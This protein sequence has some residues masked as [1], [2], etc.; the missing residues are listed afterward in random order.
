[1]KKIILVLGVILVCFL[2]GCSGKKAAVPT[3][4]TFI[5][6]WGATE[7]DHKA[8][9][10]IYMD[11]EKENPDIKINMLSMPTN[12]EMINFVEDM[13]SV[14]TVPD[15][16]FTAGEG[17]NSIYR[18]MLENDMLVDLAPYMEKDF[19]F[20]TSISPITKVTWKQQDHLYTASDVLIVSGGY[21]YNKDLLEL[22][23]IEKIPTTWD[24]FFKMLETINR[25]SQARFSTVEAIR[26]STNTYLYIA[27]NI[28]N[29]SGEMLTKGKIKMSEESFAKVC[30]TWK[31]LDDNIHMQSR[32][33][34]YRDE[35]DLFN[36]G[37]LAIYPNGVWAAS[38]IKPDIN[39]GYALF[40]SAYGQTMSC[41]SAA[42]GYLVGNTGNEEKIQ[43][44][45]RFLTYMLSLPVQK[46]IL[47]ETQQ[48]PQNPDIEI[49]D[50]EKELERFSMA[51]KEI[52]SAKIRLDIPQN[53]WSESQ[54]ETIELY[55]SSYLNGGL[56]EKSFYQMCVE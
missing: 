13:L 45:I 29:D 12:K 38:M 37:K 51:V 42:L 26:P 28:L 48:M 7:E 8:M 15:I 21:W 55:L 50:Y 43:A 54:R 19:E 27:D 30:D 39:A 4:I 46:R 31:R 35:T 14:G 3:E 25:W 44:S 11:F 47:L 41:Q 1:M 20:E 32:N 5:H 18:F 52:Q 40:P 10:Q 22:I 2:S 33:I 6:G 49:A 34:S 9:R 56:E 16:I 23:G 17:E 24:D 53:L 36:N